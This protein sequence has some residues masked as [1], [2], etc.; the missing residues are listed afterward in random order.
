MVL[1]GFVFL[2]TIRIS[3]NEGLEGVPVVKGTEALLE[4]CIPT[5]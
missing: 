3:K 1:W 4:G 5:T 2:I